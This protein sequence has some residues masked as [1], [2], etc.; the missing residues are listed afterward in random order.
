MFIVH[1]CPETFFM[2]WE[3]ILSRL[4]HRCINYITTGRLKCRFGNLAC[5]KK[6]LSCTAMPKL[7][8]H[9]VA[10]TTMKLSY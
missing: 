2:Q 3:Y 1:V 7:Q 9:G 8:K 6:L 10:E 4:N 5:G